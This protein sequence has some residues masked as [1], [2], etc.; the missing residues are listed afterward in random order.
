M[1]KVLLVIL[2]SSA[3]SE[4]DNCG[5]NCPQGNCPECPCGSTP[6]HYDTEHACGE[7]SGWDQDECNCIA[8]AESGGNLNA[9]NYNKKSGT[10]DVG[11]WQ[12]NTI[13]WHACNAGAPPCDLSA[14]L[15]C[16]MMVY[17]WGRETWT[18]W[19]TCHQCNCCTTPIEQPVKFIY[20]P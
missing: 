2:L 19:S 9:V 10:Y 14:N 8:K 7:Y 18:H 6:A 20:I 12:I 17:K 5:G 16:A 11:M 3:F 15:K 1:L 4:A 13:N